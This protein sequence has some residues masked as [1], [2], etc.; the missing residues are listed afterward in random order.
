[1]PVVDAYQDRDH[2]GIVYQRV[3]GPWIPQARRHVVTDTF[4][5]KDNLS[6]RIFSRNRTT[7]C[8]I[9]VAD[10]CGQ[11]VIIAASYHSSASSQA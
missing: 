5:E 8:F 3:I 2:V 1:M 11:R 6:L 4:I 7:V 10:P 9:G